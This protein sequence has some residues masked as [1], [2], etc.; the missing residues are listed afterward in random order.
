MIWKLIARARGWE[1]A[2]DFDADLSPNLVVWHPELGVH[3]D[4]S[5]A[6]RSAALHRDDPL[7]VVVIELVSVLAFIAAVFVIDGILSGRL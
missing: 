6:W 1:E 5:D 4:G 2:Y 7:I 3:Y